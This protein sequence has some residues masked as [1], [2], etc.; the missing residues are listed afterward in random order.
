MQIDLA[1]YDY[2]IGS[3]LIIVAICS[4]ITPWCAYA[5]NY[6]ARLINTSGFVLVLWE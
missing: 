2:R 1:R 6:S 4:S 3:D 5:S